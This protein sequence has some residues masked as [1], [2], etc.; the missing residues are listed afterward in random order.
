[1]IDNAIAAAGP[2]G[3][4]S[5]RVERETTGANG[6]MERW[7]D[8]LVEDDGPGPSPA[9]R[10]RLFE[11]F[12]TGKRDGIGLGLAVARRLMEEDGGAVD[13]MRRDGRTVFRA[14]CRPAEAVRNRD[15][16]G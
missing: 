11:P 4:V 15:E 9:V 3:A 14:R 5:I 6:A 16:R 13:W 7:I 2:N 10:D 12:T 8:V 1:L